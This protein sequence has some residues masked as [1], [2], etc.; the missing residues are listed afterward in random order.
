MRLLL[1]ALAGLAILAVATLLVVPRF[2][3]WNRFKPE[4][5]ALA[6]RATG[7]QLAIDGDVGFSLLPT[8]T[9]SAAGVRLS[10]A[11]G[12]AEPD[13]VR[14]KSLDA[15]IA[16]GPL[17]GGRIVAESIV[18]VEPSLVV[19]PAAAA[20]GGWDA[21][22]RDRL[23]FDRIIVVDGSV[24]WRGADGALRLDKINAEITG[25]ASAGAE[26]DSRLR[27]S[28]DVAWQGLPWRFDLSVGRLAEAAPVSLSLGLR[29]G[30]ANLRLSG[31]A[32]LGSRDTL[33]TGRLR[34][35]GNRLPELLAAFGVG[36][37]L[38]APLGQAMTVEATLQVG[39]SRIAL[40]DLAL[41]LGDDLRASGAAG[42]AL[43][44]QG[45]FDLVLAV[46]RLDVE[47][48]STALP[49]RA[50]AVVAPP[51]LHGTIDLTID[52]LLW[53][54]GVIR[55]ARL[56]GVLGAAGLTVKQAAAQLPGGSD[57]ALFGQL[58]LGDAPRFDGQLEGGADNLRSLFAWLKLDA[59]AIPAD[60][61]RRVSV[62]TGLSIARDAIELANLDL[63]FDG[64]RLTGGVVATL[65]ARPAFGVNL[66]LDRINLEA[67]LPRAGNRSAAP[68]PPI[69][70]SAPLDW[71]TGFDANLQLQV[72]QLSYN[73]VPLQGVL[74]DAS[75][76]AGTLRLNQLTTE[77][78]A[79]VRATLGG[80]MRR[81]RWPAELELT[82]TAQ[83]DD[84]SRLLQL[85]GYDLATPALGPLSATVSATGPL[86][87]LRLGIDAA[88]AGGTF[89]A[90]SDDADLLARG[91][92]L[93]V[94]VR[95]DEALRLLRALIPGY[96]PGGDTVG[97]LALTGTV[98]L[99]AGRL[100]L[101]DGA[102]KLG[103]AGLAVSGGADLGNPR[104]D[105]KL[106]LAGPTLMLDPLLPR[107][108][109]ERPPTPLGADLW[110]VL[111]GLPATVA[112]LGPLD[113][114][115]AVEL[116][117]LDYHGQHAT[118]IALDLTLQAGSPAA[119]R[120]AADG[121][122]GRLTLSATLDPAHEPAL[123][124]RA[125]L[126]GVKADQAAAAL[127]GV[128][129]LDGRLDLDAAATAS[130]ATAVELLGSLV[131]SAQLRLRDG[132]IAGFDLAALNGRL[133][134]GP[135]GADPAR[136]VGQDLARGKT[137]F[138]ALDGTLSLN[139]AQLATEDAK[140]VGPGGT[141][142]LRGGLDLAARQLDLGAVLE[143]ADAPAAPSAR[144]HLTGA[145][146]APSRAIDDQALVE[147]LAVRQP[148]A[149]V[150]AKPGS[151]GR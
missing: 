36:G 9:L 98:A 2:I 131:G 145:L 65:G 45:G 83:A 32:T 95:H 114:D 97:A 126:S 17:L 18:L 35:D 82:L 90:A 91:G 47:R 34:A 141:V 22:W 63:Q 28:G 99:A 108:L 59:D 27:V 144:I 56:A 77:S 42:L 33:L 101:A 7:R 15:R 6:E 78:A 127:L 88:V 72:D 132:E 61:L 31:T 116:G 111:T 79:G 151:G 53:R 133:Q 57:V 54:G 140:L 139:G 143:L 26:G 29:G 46:N 100:T 122:G 51:A 20:L 60:R 106:R 5:A 74:V 40:N 3:D 39:A 70:G 92:T 13:L 103:S 11:P 121:W 105:L 146:A 147:F 62:T 93:A 128:A 66:R 135:P 148:R 125:A 84:P 76:E 81:A 80:I 24:E 118:G 67:Y 96:R 115:A 137:A 112:A 10:A 129:P 8:P 142:A 50:P 138:S 113:V 44:P 12:A 134:P 102:L 110:A 130:G 55:Q 149:P 107:R 68:A 1:V 117:A 4:I 37:A 64:S 19:E 16:F 119:A 41:T 52:A 136:L 94:A 30:G 48:W 25:P 73:T 21:G 43:P 75:L 123:A 87:H 104:L 38:P 23:G 71:L 86:D 89:H 109:A 85:L 150:V 58:T 14:L 120:L 69:A 124:L 49:P